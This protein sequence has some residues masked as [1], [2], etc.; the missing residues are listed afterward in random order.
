MVTRQLM[1]LKSANG[2]ELCVYRVVRFCAFYLFIL[3][4]NISAVLT[5]S[6]VQNLLMQINGAIVVIWLWNLTSPSIL[7]ALHVEIYLFFLRLPAF[8]CSALYVFISFTF[9]FFAMLTYF[10]T[11]N[12]LWTVKTARKA[13]A[14][15][16]MTSPLAETSATPAS[17]V[18][19]LFIKTDDPLCFMGFGI[20]CGFL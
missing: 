15:L 18:Q 19:E 7:N 5:H 14:I 16:K 3:V 4:L 1:M 12:S 2:H 17:Y 13:V 6:C 11:Q 20:L 8:Y 9:N 10:Y